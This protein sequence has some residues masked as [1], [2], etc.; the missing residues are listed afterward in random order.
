M[1]TE[2]VFVDGFLFVSLCDVCAFGIGVSLGSVGGFLEDVTF[3]ERLALKFV[4][5]IDG[6]SKM[7]GTIC[8]ELP[9]FELFSANGLLNELNERNS[10][11]SVASFVVHVVNIRRHDDNEF[12]KRLLIPVDL[13]AASAPFVSGFIWN[14]DPNDLLSKVCIFAGN[15][16]SICIFDSDGN[17][18]ELMHFLSQ[19]AGHLFLIDAFRLRILGTIGEMVQVP[20]PF[21]HCTMFN[22]DFSPAT[23][24]FFTVFDMNFLQVSQELIPYLRD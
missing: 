20:S 24:N 18:Y 13:E 14:E 3:V 21:L 19:Q 10:V 1:L 17:R 5:I 4:D 2:F 8:G 9:N 22:G 7:F 11:P 23:A 6:F 16:F 12:P 15:S